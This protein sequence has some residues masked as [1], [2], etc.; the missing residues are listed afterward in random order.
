MAKL[1]RVRIDITFPIPDSADPVAE[2]RLICGID[3][4]IG[5]AQHGIEGGHDG[6][7]WRENFRLVT[8]KGRGDGGEPEPE[9]AG[10]DPGGA[11][12]AGAGET[13]QEPEAGAAPGTTAGA[14]GA[15]SATALT[16][17][18][19][20]A[21]AAQTTAAERRMRTGARG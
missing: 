21:A 17:A 11:E 20:E 13:A 18:E 3:D 6:V 4:R 7:V 8:L 19:I 1:L 9:P 15:A 2:A 16:P 12:G 10:G 5:E 14:D